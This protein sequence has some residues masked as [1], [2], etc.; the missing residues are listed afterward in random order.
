[1]RRILFMFLMLS[2]AGCATTGTHLSIMDGDSSKA[3]KNGNNTLREKIAN[4]GKV[5]FLYASHP[6]DYLN[7][8]SNTTAILTDG[9]WFPRVN[10]KLQEICDEVGGRST[11]RAYDSFTGK[12]LIKGETPSPQ[13]RRWTCSGGSVNFSINTVVTKAV[14][15]AQVG[16]KHNKLFILVQSENSGS[17]VLTYNQNKTITD[18]KDK[19]LREFLDARF[20]LIFGKASSKTREQPD[21]A[22]YQQYTQEYGK[23]TDISK[24]L[25]IIYDLNAYCAYHGGNF[26]FVENFTLAR[27]TPSLI[28]DNAI[29]QCTSEQK[30]FFVKFNVGNTFRNNYGEIKTRYSILA[31]EGRVDQANLLPGHLIE[32]QTTI[33][34]KNRDLKEMLKNKFDLN[35]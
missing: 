19:S 34:E 18:S 23:V 8:D 13:S 26:V 22:L 33:N 7:L 25:G 5:G 3:A 32:K 2:I 29:M 16:H 30:P 15:Q 24:D 20:G 1:M 4:I 21:G 27:L 11:E 12:E 9:Y 6:V 28:P 17:P 31:K 14:A 10:I 35:Y